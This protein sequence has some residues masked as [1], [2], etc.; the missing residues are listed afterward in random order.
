M[1]L[2]SHLQP[3]ADLLV[4]IGSPEVGPKLEQAKPGITKHP[5]A[6]FLG[7]MAKDWE[8]ANRRWAMLTEWSR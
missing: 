2:D 7:Y 1:T 5:Q 8:V 6:A 4:V 3:L